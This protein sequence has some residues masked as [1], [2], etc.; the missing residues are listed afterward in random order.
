MGFAERECAAQPTKANRASTE[1]GPDIVPRGGDGEWE[2][3]TLAAGVAM[4]VSFGLMFLYAG[5]MF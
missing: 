2:R 3:A 4:A 1:N 5:V